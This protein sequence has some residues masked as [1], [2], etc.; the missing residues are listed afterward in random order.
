[1]DNEKPEATPRNRIHMRQTV[2]SSRRTSSNH[3]MVNQVGTQRSLLSK[4]KFNSKFS[5]NSGQQYS[6]TKELDSENE[7]DNYSWLPYKDHPYPELRIDDQLKNDQSCLQSNIKKLKK[8]RIQDK[9]QFFSNQ[10]QSQRRIGRKP[11]RQL[12]NRKINLDALAQ[13]QNDAMKSLTNGNSSI[14]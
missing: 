5:V 7:S 4:N 10:S 9:D 11:S 6:E 1:M 12:T 2:S 3:L 13:K 14:Q 8:D